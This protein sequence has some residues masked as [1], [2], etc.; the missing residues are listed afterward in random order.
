MFQL[1]ILCWRVFYEIKLNSDL[2]KEFLAFN[3]QRSVF[4]ELMNIIA[5][6][7]FS[8]YFFGKSHCTNGHDLISEISMRFFNCMCKNFVH[9]ISVA[10]SEKVVKR[11]IAKLTNKVKAC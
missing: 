8:E 1:C 2:R 10:S 5:L 9:D 3:N 6:G 7:D 11:K 4:R